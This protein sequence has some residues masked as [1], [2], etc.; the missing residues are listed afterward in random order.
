MK[1]NLSVTLISSLL[2][3]SSFY[4]TKFGL[5][6]VYVLLPLLF[7][8]WFTLGFKSEA[9]KLKIDS[10]FLLSILSVL[11]LF[12]NNVFR[13]NEFTWPI[14]IN[15]IIAI[16][17]LLV[18]RDLTYKFSIKDLIKAIGYYNYFIIVIVSLDTFFRFKYPIVNSV[19]QVQGSDL[20]FYQYKRS[21][22][23]GDSNVVSILLMTVM[24]FNLYVM[25]K[26][27]LKVRSNR[28]TIFILLFLLFLTFSRAAY[29]AT[30]IGLL[31]VMVYSNVR[32][33]FIFYV[34]GSCTAL[35]LIP[36]IVDAVL[37]DG[38]GGTKLG[39]LVNVVTFFKNVNSVYDTLFG[40]GFG[41]GIYVMDMYIHGLFA[42][43]LVEGGLVFFS[44]Y[45]LLLFLI[46]KVERKVLIIYVPL[47]VASISLSF[48]IISAFQGAILGLVCLLAANPKINDSLSKT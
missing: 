18:G 8:S 21:F 7:L 4:L 13:A 30:F 39:E 36:F 42:K 10:I 15:Y 43:L 16:L 17:C 48:Y 11:V 14:V 25:E 2:V 23:L 29:V 41:N 12:F 6:P 33:R 35:F 37:R 45:I 19:F 28:M 26:F 32:K 3:F 20:W 38:S 46:Y 24:F 22:I 1:L 44:L 31:Y 40:V 47:L 27:N 5:S 9:S 34:L